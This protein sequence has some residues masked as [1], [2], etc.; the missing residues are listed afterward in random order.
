[1]WED[2][3]SKIN[4]LAHDQNSATHYED[5]K[6]SSCMCIFACVSNVYVG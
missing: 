2:L 1:M 3:L 6:M 5:K 4:D